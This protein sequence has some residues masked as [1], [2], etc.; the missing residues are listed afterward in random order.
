MRIIINIREQNRWKIIHETLH[1][2]DKEGKQKGSF[3]QMIN[4]DNHNKHGAGMQMMKS[5]VEKG[6]EY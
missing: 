4:I 5:C 6:R 3:S 2:D 1:S